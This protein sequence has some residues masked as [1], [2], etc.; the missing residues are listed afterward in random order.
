MTANP[1][2]AERFVLRHVRRAD[3]LFDRVYGA[4]F[5]PLYQSGTIVVLL[6]LVVIVSG[7]WL[8]LFYRVGAPWQSVAQITLNGWSGNWVRGVHRYA[9]DLAVLATVIHALRMF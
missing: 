2:P 4:A 9:S 3:T 5:N 6:Y 7:L 1:L 8:L